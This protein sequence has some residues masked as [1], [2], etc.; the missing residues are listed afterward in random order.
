MTS[1]FKDMLRTRHRDEEAT[2]E[3]AKPARRQGKRNNPDYVQT[4]AYIRRAVH[5]E[6]QI[7]L[8]RDGG[9]EFSELVEEL[10]V[11]WNHRQASKG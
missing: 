7:N 2:P 6:T 3:S 5:E 9:R 10:L 4:T 11:A 8:I 1:K